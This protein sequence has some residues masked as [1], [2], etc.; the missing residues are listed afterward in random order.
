MLDRSS[1]DWDLWLD[2]VSQE[3]SR[4]AWR[5]IMCFLRW[6]QVRALN[7]HAV[8]GFLPGLEDDMLHSMLLRR[9]LD[10]KEPLL[11]PPP[12]SFGKGW[13][14][15]LELGK[16]DNVSV[17]RWEWSPDQK[18]AINDGVWTILERRGETEYVVTYRD[19]GERFRLS[20]R[21]DGS[22]AIERDSAN[23]TS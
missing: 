23:S 3:R 15:L 6:I 7:G 18:I 11:H 5:G 21:K 22:W 2:E 10:R 8:P 14:E 13:Y 4:E 16:A 9:L 1:E 17:R 19:G 12:E 20:Q